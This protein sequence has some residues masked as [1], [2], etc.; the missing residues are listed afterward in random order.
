MPLLH[1]TI[2]WTCC[3]AQVCKHTAFETVFRIEM[4]SIHFHYSSSCLRVKSHVFDFGSKEMNSNTTCS[5][6]LANSKSEGQSRI[7]QT[8]IHKLSPSAVLFEEVPWAGVTW[9]RTKC[10]KL[11]HTRTNKNTLLPF[12]L[13]ILHCKLRIVATKGPLTCEHTHTVMALYTAPK[14]CCL[15]QK[16]EGVTL[17]FW[18]MTKQNN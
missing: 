15:V 8:R 10:A 4:M 14:Q 9:S 3:I 1:Q 16:T 5:S 11:A 18:S 2:L 7:S 12:P 13:V 17:S 6:Y